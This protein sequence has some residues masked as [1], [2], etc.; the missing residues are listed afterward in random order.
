MNTQEYLNSKGYFAEASH[1]SLGINVK[2]TTTGETVFRL[3]VA[4]LKL[5]ATKEQTIALIN[6]KLG[7]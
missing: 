6:Q 3:S 2:R 4:E 5:N 7:L 1:N